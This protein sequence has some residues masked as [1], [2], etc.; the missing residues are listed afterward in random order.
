MRASDGNERG[1]SAAH[2]ASAFVAHATDMTRRVGCTESLDIGKTGH[3]AR[4]TRR[5][6]G[7]RFFVACRSDRVTEA[8]HHGACIA[9]R[10]AELIAFE[11]IVTWS[12]AVTDRRRIVSVVLDCDLGLRALEDDRSEAEVE[13]RDAACAPRDVD[14]AKRSC[15]QSTALMEGQPSL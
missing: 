1:H 8:P 4:I 11:M 2:H 12:P 14:A 6:S 3:V 13:L 7:A 9:S 10:A 15:G 5:H